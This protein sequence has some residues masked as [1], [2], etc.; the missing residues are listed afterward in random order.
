MKR[1]IYSLAAAGLLAVPFALA[2]AGGEGKEP[3]KIVIRHGGPGFGH[4]PGHRMFFGGGE[5]MPS[6][7]D[8]LAKAL[9]LTDDQKAAAKE[10]E[11]KMKATME[12]IHADMERV[13]EA[14]EQALESNAPAA[15]VGA[16]AIEAYQIRQKAKTAHTE[17]HAQFQE[18][19]TAEQREKFDSFHHEMRFKHGH[20]GK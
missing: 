7:V 20:H 9:D 11:T 2:H 14:M 16:L 5:G 8:H 6:I 12:P 19:L 17:I 3:H 4:G 13:H 18:I 1:W 10:I 15:T